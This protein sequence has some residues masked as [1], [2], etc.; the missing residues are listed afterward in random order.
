M[1]VKG[2]LIRVVR[3]KFRVGKHVRISEETMKF[4]VGEQNFS[5]EKFWNAK[6]TG[7]RPRSFYEVE[8]LNRKPIDAQFYQEE[9]TVVGESRNTIYKLDKILAERVRRGIQQYL[10]LSRVYSRDF[11]SC[12]PESSLKDVRQSSDTFLRDVVQ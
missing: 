2:L 1:D 11:D 4:E 3:T 10:V 9:L 7:R 12:I 5:T 6:V 8:E